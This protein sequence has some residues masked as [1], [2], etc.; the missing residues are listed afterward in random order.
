MV[1]VGHAPSEIGSG[2]L[3]YALE[4]PLPSAVQWPPMSQ[5]QPGIGL[6]RHVE[7]SGSTPS[8]SSVALIANG[9]REPSLK[10]I[11]C[12]PPTKES[13]CAWK[14]A[15]VTGALLGQSRSVA[16]AAVHGSLDSMARQSDSDGSSLSAGVTGVAAA[17]LRGDRPRHV[18]RAARLPHGRRAGGKHLRALR[19]HVVPVRHLGRIRAAA[20]L[21]VP[22]RRAA[23]VAHGRAAW[24]APWVILCEVAVL[25]V[26]AKPRARR[27]ETWQHIGC[28]L[29]TSPSPRDAHES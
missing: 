17:V 13:G 12:V 22:R 20:A 15:S 14:Q 11:V 5:L 1:P 26:L 21:L 9:A 2:A 28:L 23:G 10:R 29:Y 25:A 6:R 24:A 18:R 27:A 8:L 7:P 3:A 16:Q 4:K 19:P